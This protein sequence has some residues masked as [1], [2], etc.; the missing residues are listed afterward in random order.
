MTLRTVTA[1]TKDTAGEP[2]NTEWVFCS[3]LRGADG[4]IITTRPKTVKPAAGQLTV[5]LEPGP[6]IVMYGGRKLT[7]LVPD[8]D[9]DLWELLEAAIAYPPDTSQQQLNTAVGQY[10]EANRQQFRTRAVPVDPDDPDTLYQWVDSNGDDVGDPVELADI[11]TVDPLAIGAITD[12]DARL[13]DTRTPTDGSVT[14]AKL[15]AAFAATL[16]TLAGAQTLTNKTLTSPKMATLLDANGNTALILGATASAVNYLE[17]DNQAAGSA[18]QIRAFGSDS[19]VGIFLRP[20]GN[21]PVTIYT[22]AGQTPRLVANGADDNLNLNLVPKGT[23]V[24]QANG[25]AVATIS[26]T[27]TLTNKTLDLASNTLAGTTAQFNSALSDDDFATLTNAVTLTNKTLTSPK[28]GTNLL[29]TNGNT[30]L[31]ITATAS[32]VNYIHFENAALGS[33]PQVRALGSDSNVAVMLRPKG[34]QSVQIYAAT[35]QTPTLEAVGADTDHNLAFKA[36]GA[37]V[38]LF[39]ATTTA[40]ASLRIPHGTAPTSPTDGD[41]WT[42]TAG[43]FVRING[44]TKTV[45]LT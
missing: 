24:V 18:P 10:V 32:A 5:Q 28:I 44:V 11:V 42:T 23:G 29:D 7:I 26:G 6:T 30:L 4:E 15:E 35:S 38:P 41:M 37:G 43:L 9:A 14:L 17:I 31:G 20:K 33:P 19:D 1:T 2:D 8:E 40:R 21:A 45:T 3:E 36:K 25:V 27:Q 22:A 16:A 34:A 12:Y 13:D 39:P